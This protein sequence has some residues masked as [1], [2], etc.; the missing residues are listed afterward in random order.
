MKQMLETS[1]SR[2][3]VSLEQQIVVIAADF[4]RSC[5]DSSVTNH[6]KV[7][8]VTE[9]VQRELDLRSDVSARFAALMH[10]RKEVPDQSRVDARVI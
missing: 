5:N 4:A 6:M 8:I 10:A 2:A 9:I 7:A 1:G 3:S